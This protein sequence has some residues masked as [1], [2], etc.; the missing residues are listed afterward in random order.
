MI[1]TKSFTLAGYS[2]GNPAAEKVALVLPGRL[3]TKDYANMQNHVSFFAELGFF[4]LSFDPP[5]TW[6][7]PGGMVLYTMTNYLKAINELIEYLGN[8][9]TILMGHSR[10]GSM[11]MLGG[12]ENPHVTHFIAVMS[13]AT[14]SMPR[15]SMKP[16]DV[17]IS[18][19]DMP[20]NVQEKKKFELPFSFFE[21]SA[22]YTMLD[23]L[24][25]CRKPKLFI[26]SRSDT[27]VPLADVQQAYDAAAQP[28]WMRVID[29]VH[30]YR[31]HPHSI[32]EVNRVMGEF[33]KESKA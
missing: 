27:T 17:Q 3:D 13:R 23:G 10:G 5:G 25:Q 9:K 15:S 2:K 7:S 18:C 4:A 29:S 1:K 21:D 24:G 33:L 8:K 26:G 6:G 22:R 19:R 11:A 20:G 12:I 30:D 28:K 14:M 16:G 31:L 32:D